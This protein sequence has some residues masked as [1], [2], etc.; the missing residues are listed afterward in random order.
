MLSYQVTAKSMPH[1][2]INPNGSGTLMD[3]QVDLDQGQ[4]HRPH[5]AAASCGR[6]HNLYVTGVSPVWMMISFVHLVLML[7]LIGVYVGAPA[8]DTG[9]PH[10]EI[11]FTTNRI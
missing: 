10:F 4:F 11:Y 9:W 8:D 5:H 7:W 3:D 1:Q 2:G 6:T